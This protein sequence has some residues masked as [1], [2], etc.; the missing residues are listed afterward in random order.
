MY[1]YADMHASLLKRAQVDAKAPQV[2]AKA[3]QVDAK[4][5]QVDGKAHQV[6]AKAR[7]VDAKTPQ[8]DAKVPQVAANTS[9][10]GL[11]GIPKCT[12]IRLNMHKNANMHQSPQ[13]RPKCTQR[14]P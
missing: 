6:D 10:S 13:L 5:P 14:P 4:A 2:D 11:Q 1:G 3:P 12:R 9:P 7:Q 8:V